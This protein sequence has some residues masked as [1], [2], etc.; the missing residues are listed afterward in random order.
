M[1]HILPRSPNTLSTRLEGQVSTRKH[2][3]NKPAHQTK[4][5]NKNAHKTDLEELVRAV[6]ADFRR[7]GTAVFTAYARSDG[8]HQ[9]L[10]ESSPVRKKHAKLKMSGQDTSTSA[11]ERQA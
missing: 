2:E 6:L 4:P 1:A 11:R 10:R 3:K 8:L 9:F 5:R 7:K